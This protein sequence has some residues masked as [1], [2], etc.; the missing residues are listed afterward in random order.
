M[1]EGGTKWERGWPIDEVEGGG[2][3]G[4]MDVRM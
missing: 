3:R 4:T 2:G 1:G